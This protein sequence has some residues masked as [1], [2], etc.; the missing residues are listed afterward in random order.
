VNFQHK[1]LV[2]DPKRRL[3]LLKPRSVVEVEQ[4]I[5]VRLGN[6]KP[7]RELYL[8]EA[9]P[10]E[11]QIQFDLGGLQGGQ[12]NRPVLLPRR[13]PGF[14]TSMPLSMQSAR[15]IFKASPAISVASSSLSAWVTPHSKSGKVMT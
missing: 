5:D 6:A 4:T 15:S 2:Q 11:G 12:R 7:S 3:D 8:P 1:A 13:L 10:Q 14:G 9:R